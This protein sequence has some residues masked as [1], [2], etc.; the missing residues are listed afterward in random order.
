[1]DIELIIERSEKIPDLEKRLEKLEEELKERDE[2][3]TLPAWC[4]LRQIARYSGMSY[5]GLKKSPK[6]RPLGGRMISGAWRFQR[7][8]VIKW[9]HS[10][11]KNNG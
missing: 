3:A 4:T 6:K 8:D 2:A 10:L 1:M 9:I 5:D 7:E 11:G